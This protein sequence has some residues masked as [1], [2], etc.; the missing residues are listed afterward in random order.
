MKVGISA[1]VVGLLGVALH[2]LPKKSTEFLGGERLY[3]PVQESRLNQ[4]YKGSDG[5]VTFERVGDD[6]IATVQLANLHNVGLDLSDHFS[7]PVLGYLFDTNGD[8]KVDWERREVA[9]DFFD[10]E[11]DIRQPVKKRL[12]ELAS[13]EG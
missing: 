11:K 1:S 8:G 5:V 12:Q 6:Y 3:L 7:S 10:W 4:R 9:S 2:F 13:M